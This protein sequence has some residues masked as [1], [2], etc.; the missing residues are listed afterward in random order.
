MK[1]EQIVTTHEA[2]WPWRRR[3]ERKPK[4]VW[5]KALLQ[6]VVAALVASLMFYLG[7]FLV[8][9]TI[10]IIA[11]V[12]IITGTLM[13]P[14]YKKI[15]AFGQKLGKY[16]AFL[17]SWLLLCPFYFLFFYP[18]ALLSRGKTRKNF[19]SYSSETPNS[20]WIARPVES[21]IENYKRQ[22]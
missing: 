16:A 15:E 13:I 20:Y 10:W 7:H 9:V 2:V 11:G 21:S 12:L 14:V 22:Y 8:A 5:K 4:G 6:S 3:A 17:L 18:L 1:R 19:S